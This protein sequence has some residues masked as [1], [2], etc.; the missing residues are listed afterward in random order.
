MDPVL[1][2]LKMT[3]PPFM[4][5]DFEDTPEDLPKVYNITDE[6]F[7]DM[8]E[9]RD[10]PKVY[11]VTDEVFEDIPEE[12]NLKVGLLHLDQINGNWK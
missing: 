1:A 3:H 12:D 5:Q 9:D 10:L 7:E 6:V 8:P 11:N 2:K 4:D